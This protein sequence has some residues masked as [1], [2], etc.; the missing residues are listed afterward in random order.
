MG[1]FFA[2]IVAIGAIPI[3]IVVVLAVILI[4]KSYV[5]S[6]PDVAFIVSGMMKESRVIIG[7]SGL[8]IPFLQRIDRVYLELIQVDVRVSKV[9]TNDFV[10]VSIDSVAN[11]RVSKDPELIQR[12]AQNFLNKQPSEIAPLVQ[13]VLE[14]NIREIIGQMDVRSIVTD[15]QTF[16]Q[17]VQDN[18]VTDMQSLG[19]ELVSF[20]I[21]DVRD[22]KDVI[23]NL[24]AD[25]LAKI[26][27]DAAVARADAE[28]EMKVRGAEANKLGEEARIES[29]KLIAEKENELALKKSEL[30]KQADRAAAEAA[31]VTEI[32][33]ELQ[34]KTVNTNRV[35][36]EIERVKQE[37]A[38][39]EHQSELKEKE[40][41]ADIRKQ[42]DAEKYAAEQKALAEK[43]VKQANAEAS[44]YTVQREA[45]ARMAK[46]EADKTAAL[47]EAEGVK[48]KL[49]AEAAGIRAKALAEAEGV[50]AKALAEAEG[51][52][53]KAEA[54]AKMKDAAVLE[55][56]FNALPQ[57]AEAMAKP[58]ESV[59]SIIMYGDQTTKL[60]ESGVKNVSQ[61][62]EILKNT[63]GIDLA[64]IVG[65]FTKITD[66][67]VD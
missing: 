14:G 38:L 24:G 31:A 19:L 60:V 11:V 46:A 7:R 4:V 34:N 53:K 62:S 10:E 32:E 39:A 9:P 3:I 59:D 33:R 63:V 16:N 28:R 56:A 41:N 42:A 65:K 20:N 40:L 55:M 66:K 47:L 18:V 67:A 21:Q 36:A 1:D 25:N 57:I 30:K 15:K 6:P 54:M 61:V 50:K 23:A 64:D 37:T 5:K 44:L 17:M 58:L 26:R 22:E 48:A 52:E 43:A 35:Q 12:A 45:E 2:S 27:K 13:Q 29:E 49:E 8:R 51:L